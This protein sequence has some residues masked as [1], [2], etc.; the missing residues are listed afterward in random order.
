LVCAEPKALCQSE[1]S[2]FQELCVELALKCQIIPEYMA[3]AKR[4]AERLRAAAA[5]APA[6][7]ALEALWA[8]LSSYWCVH[9][10]TI[11]AYAIEQRLYQSNVI[12]VVQE[13]R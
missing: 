9:T 1:V 5:A 2:N 12:H 8:L 13:C 11:H 3:L 4:T 7:A 6:L 10:I